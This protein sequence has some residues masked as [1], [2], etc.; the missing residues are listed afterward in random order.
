[1]IPPLSGASFERESLPTAITHLTG[2][3]LSVM[4][5]EEFVSQHIPKKGALIGTWNNLPGNGLAE[6]IVVR[7]DDFVETF[8]WFNAFFS[9]LSPITQWCRVMR[10][11]TASS[12]SESIVDERPFSGRLSSWVGAILAECSVQSGGIQ[13]LKDIPGSAALSTATFAA[14]RAAAIWRSRADLRLIAKRH[15][16]LSSALSREASRPL[17]AAKLLPLWQVLEG[18]TDGDNF[19]ANRQLEPLHFL[20]SNIHTSST[21]PDPAE[22]V[23]RLAEQARFYFDIPEL[24]ECAEGPQLSRVRALDK[25]AV[26]LASGPGSFEID[27]ILG[28]GASFIDPGASVAGDLLRRYTKHFPLAAIWQGAFAG[29][30]N[31]MRVMTDHVGLGRVISKSLLAND[32]LDGRPSSDIA[33]DEVIRWVTPGRSLKLDVRSLS[34]SAITVELVAGVTCSFPLSRAGVSSA[35]SSTVSSS[36]ASAVAASGSLRTDYRQDSDRSRYGFAEVD[37]AIRSLQQRVAKLEAQSSASQ[38]SLDLPQPKEDRRKSS[39]QTKTNR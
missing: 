20:L 32:D 25:L 21:D 14:G 7:D 39:R 31:P 22:Q 1:M 11:S 23:A 34:A 4:S 13:S 12:L 35:A 26:R 17:T 30:L 6:T 19:K 3:S 24:G 29:A 16:D 38:S 8:A 36:S 28:I 27:G 18:H 37:A 15:D 9:A 2:Q 10:H 5:W 33:F